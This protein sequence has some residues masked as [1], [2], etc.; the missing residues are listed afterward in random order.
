M[1]SRGCQPTWPPRSCSCGPSRAR[2][3]C[4][5]GSSAWDQSCSRTSKAARRRSA[6]TNLARRMIHHQREQLVPV[7][8]PTST[9]TAGCSHARR[10]AQ[11]TDARSRRCRPRFVLAHARSRW[12]WRRRR[13]HLARGHGRLTQNG[14]RRGTRLAGVLRWPASRRV[15]PRT[16]SRPREHGTRAERA[17]NPGPRKAPVRRHRK[18]VRQIRAVDPLDIS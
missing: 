4:V 7:R 9:C 14:D 8:L 6:R 11:L 15:S 12:L 17:I 10:F 13:E 1:P 3:I 16:C 2:R 5:L 18:L